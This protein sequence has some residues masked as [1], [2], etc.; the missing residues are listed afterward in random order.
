[1]GKSEPEHHAENE[2]S[3]ASQKEPLLDAYGNWLFKDLLEEAIF[4]QEEYK[5]KLTILAAF[6]VKGYDIDWSQLFKKG[7]YHRIPL[8]IYPFIGESYGIEETT[9]SRIAARDQSQA[10]FE[11]G[12]E[13]RTAL[14]TPIW[15]EE[16]ITSVNPE[17][18]VPLSAVGT[19]SA[20]GTIPTASSLVLLYDLPD[21]EASHLQ[22]QLA[23][24][25]YC[26]KVRVN[27]WQSSQLRREQRFQDAVV[28]LIQELQYLLQSQS[29]GPMLVQVV[30]TH[31]QEASFLEALVGVLKTAQQV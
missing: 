14:L 26:H 1:M 2:K 13:T 18:P 11:S 24:G 4:D 25:G 17:N 29:A 21:V 22:I 6:Y 27:S 12:E 20:Q 19:G 9:A 7:R 30:M 28:H 31:R 23:E 15:E 5:E 8:P 10:L 16:A 3:Q